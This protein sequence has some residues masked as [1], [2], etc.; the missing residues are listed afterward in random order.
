[1]RALSVSLCLFV[2]ICASS[3]AGQPRGESSGSAAA[4]QVK[5]ETVTYSSNGDTLIGYLAV[6]TRTS[7]RRPGILVVH[8][9]WG[10]NEYARKRADM[11]AE[12]GYTAFALD[13]YGNGK[14]ATHPGDAQAFSSAVF[15][16]FDTA[17][18]RFM[19][20]LDRLKQE[21]TVDPDKIAVIGYCFGGGVA[22][23]MARQGLDVRGVV[24]FHGSLQAVSPAAPGGIHTRL[25]V[26]SGADDPFV[27]AEVV[28]AFKTEMDAA[29]A[30][31]T[32]RSFEG[33]KHS[34]TNPGADAYGEQF[35]LPLAYNQAADEK[36][37][38][39][40]QTFFDEIFGR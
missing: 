11:L 22:L 13:M 30:D 14:Q 17:K 25:L 32:F 38:A 35:N 2:A 6:D 33:A 24:S 34:F 19:A 3:C 9:W 28:D 4:P 20:A 10:Q 40:M 27:P 12:L 21:P 31:Y 23:N 29:G 8:E 5:G 37:W 26:F 15:Q 39:E 1:M 16:D 18:A 7:E 36:S